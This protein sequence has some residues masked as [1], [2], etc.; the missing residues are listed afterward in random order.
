VPA[1]FRVLQAGTMKAEFDCLAMPD[2]KPTPTEH[3]FADPFD[4]R[5]EQALRSR[6]RD[7]VRAVKDKPWFAAWFADNEIRFEN[8]HRRVASPYCAKALGAYLDRKYGGDIGRLNAA[9]G[10]R[11]ASFDDLAARRPDPILRRGPIYEDFRAFSRE[12]VKK[13]VEVTLR[14]FDNEK[15]QANRGLYR[16]T[17]KPWR[18]LIQALSRVQNRFVGK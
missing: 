16:S 14:D 12:V 2:G 11:F 6:V 7:Y 9:W 5:Y 18:E 13:H 3:G 15:R 10:T 1:L 8:L 17:G 4:P